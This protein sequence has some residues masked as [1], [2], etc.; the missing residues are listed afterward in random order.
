MKWLAVAKGL[1]LVL[2]VSVSLG[3]AADIA[4][5]ALTA[6][7]TDLTGTLTS[8][9]RAA[10]EQR[11][12]AFESEK[13]SQIGVLMVPTTQPE[14]IEQYSIRVV[15]KWKLGRKGADDGALLIIAKDDR[16]MRIE[17]G[18]GL[19]GV[20]TD[21]MSKRIISDDIVP[22]FKQ[23]DFYGGV[24]A[25]V[26]RIIGVINGEPLPP[27]RRTR[28]ERGDDSVRQ[29]LPVILVLTLVVGG[30][31]RSL[32]GR[33]PGAVATGG[34]VGI[35][36]WVLSGAIAV[37]VMAGAI[38]LVFT[39]FGGSHMGFRGIGGRGGFGGGSG[40]GGFGGGGGGFGGGGTSGKW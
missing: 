34:V 28:G 26:E 31:L 3:A 7:V 38:A 1:F 21:A 6:R 9:Q 18:Y 11:L 24:T 29:F 23:G 36:G 35:I 22:R 32:L 2:L 20:L 39:M 25:G 33:G 8:E 15:E 4:V 5:P 10:L 12:Q 19:E 16:T 17:V 40:R 13:G 27:P 14:V 37:G 30:V